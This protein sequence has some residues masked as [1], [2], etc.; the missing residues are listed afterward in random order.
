MDANNKTSYPRLA[1]AIAGTG[2]EFPRLLEKS[3]PRILDRIELL[4]GNKELIQYLDSL[5]LENRTDRRGFP[6]EVIR[7]LVLVKQVHDF[8]YP[9]LDTTPFDPFSGTGIMPPAKHQGAEPIKFEMRPAQKSQADSAQEGAAIPSGTE[10]KEDKAGSPMDGMRGKVIWPL[11]STSHDLYGSAES[12]RKGVNIYVLQGKQIGEILMHYGLIDQQ[13]LRVV[14]RMQE[15]A[16]HADK[17]IGQILVD[18][19]IIGQQELDRALCIQTGVIMVDLLSLPIPSEVLNLVPAEK[20]REMLV[21]PVANYHGKLLLACADPFGFTEAPFLTLLTGLKAEPVYAPRHEIVNR[22]NMYGV[23]KKAGDAK[24]EF[25]EPARK[26]FDS[27]PGIEAISDVLAKTQVSENDTT[28]ITLVNKLIQDAIDAGVSDIHIEL[29][30]ESPESEIRFRRDGH[31][32][33]FSSFPRAYH[34]AVVSRIKIMSGL[35]VTERRRPQDGKIS[36]NLPDGKKHADLRISIIPTFLGVEF[37]T[38]RILTSGEPL[39]LTGLGLADR[40]LQVFREQFDHSF[41]LILVCGPTG[42][43]K[44]TTLHSVMKELNSGNNK[45]WTAEDPVE[46]VQPHLCQVQVNNKAGVTF[47]SILGSFLRADPDIIMIGDMRD[48]ETAGIAL[49]ASMTSLVLS[50]LHTNSAP[51]AVARLV[52][53][54]IDSYKLSDALLAIL[55]Q[56]LVR[57]L[58]QECAERKEAS[59]HDLEEL[60][61]EYYMSSYD[62]LPSLSEREEIIGS[63]HQSW[64]KEGKLYLSHAVGCKSCSGGYKGHIGL[65]E[66]L[67]PTPRVRHLIRRHSSVGDYKEASV[68]EGMRT[69][70]QDGIEKVVRGIT[71]LTQVHIACT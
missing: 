47:A 12:L 33:D 50:A 34:Q 5:M 23:V 24:A 8:L 43:G 62:K 20:A 38:I 27:M 15:R 26:T 19:G 68:A 17:P 64:G 35:D 21:V 69:L 67:R 60:A 53:L 30:Q 11:V 42:S 31:L 49:E 6:L 63:W 54:E 61:N 3:V 70:K 25:R 40:D 18:I 39:P 10:M 52:D 48:Q 28:I 55:A 16:E 51:E 14:A 44:T 56:R 7:E 1:K 2:A 57:K 22:L 71:D 29:F 46:I 9:S 65:F 32:H 58:C 4:W 37:I 45:I 59:M 66:L 41:G 13:S 36:F